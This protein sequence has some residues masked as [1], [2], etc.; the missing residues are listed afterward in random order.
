M[1]EF[2]PLTCVEICQPHRLTRRLWPVRLQWW[3]LDPAQFAVCSAVVETRV[4]LPNLGFVRALHVRLRG[5]EDRKRALDLSSPIASSAQN[6]QDL[7]GGQNPRGR[8]RLR[9]RLAGGYLLGKKLPIKG[10]GPRP[11]SAIT[12]SSTRVT[13]PLPRLTS[14][15]SARH[16][17]VDASTTLS[18][19]LVC[20][21][22]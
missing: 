8:N 7:P 16:S 9:V 14:G 1:L 11:C 3:I 15:S 17:R 10:R 20:Q 19:C 2:I 21:G 13:R 6:L 5:T 4:I 18:D 22:S 12:S